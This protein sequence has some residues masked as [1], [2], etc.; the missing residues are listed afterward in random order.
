M[1]WKSAGI[2]KLWRKNHGSKLVST[3][4]SIHPSPPKL[5]DTHKVHS[6]TIYWP[7]PSIFHDISWCF[8]PCWGDVCDPTSPGKLAG[9]WLGLPQQHH[10]CGGPAASTPVAVE[11]DRGD[12]GDRG[13]GSRWDAGRLGGWD[14]FVKHH[15]LR[16]I[17]LCFTIQDWYPYMDLSANNVA[18]ILLG[19]PKIWDTVEMAALNQQQKWWAPMRFRGALVVSNEPVWMI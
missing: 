17:L 13:T 5:E 18:N 8:Q 19:F 1:K 15:W 9:H 11:G 6:S 12:S 2:S 3:R 14:L 4:L 16:S 10:R 7:G